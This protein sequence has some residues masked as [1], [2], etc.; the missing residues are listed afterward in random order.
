M[1]QLVPSPTSAAMSS[2]GEEWYTL[3][4]HLPD[5]LYASSICVS[6][7][8]GN[9][10]GEIVA[11]VKDGGGGGGGNAELCIVESLQELLHALRSSLKTWC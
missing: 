10:T 5:E 2:W 4:G 1:F 3:N 6:L 8:G 7:G 9:T 11:G